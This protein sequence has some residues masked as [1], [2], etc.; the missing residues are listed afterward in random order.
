METNVAQ[1]A[2]AI[3]NHEAKTE[4]SANGGWTWCRSDNNE[5]G[6]T[7]ASFC[8]QELHQKIDVPTDDYLS[9]E[10][11]FMCIK[12]RGSLL[13]FDNLDEDT[14][15]EMD[16]RLHNVQEINST[17]KRTRRE[18]QVADERQEPVRQETAD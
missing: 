1:N 4:L 16:Q 11:H 7:P 3:I 18:F 9:G 8:N 5:W 15:D 17:G 14:D 2:L 10:E 12:D 13:L 6:F